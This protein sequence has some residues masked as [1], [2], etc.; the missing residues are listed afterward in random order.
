MFSNKKGIYGYLKKQPVRIGL[1][2]LLMI[3]VSAAIF[4]TGFIIYGS[5][6]NY[7]TIPAVL[8]LLPASKLIVSFVMYLKAEKYTCS[9]EL[10]DKVEAVLANY[11]VQRLYDL[12]LTSYKLNYPIP[13]CFVDDGSLIVYLS[14]DKNLTKECKDHIEE[15]M[16]INSI[17]GFKVYVFDN[18]DKYL[19]R[20]AKVSSADSSDANDGQV[21]NLMKNLS[22]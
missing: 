11:D 4:V 17:K 2:A 5:Y 19:A 18:E 22:L 10:Y 15:Y 12:Y 8:G 9:K 3:A 16:S 7:L 21:L 20:A 1:L 13:S 6:K 14:C